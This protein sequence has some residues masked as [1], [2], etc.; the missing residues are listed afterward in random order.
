[1]LNIK[2]YYNFD[3]K[4]LKTLINMKARYTEVPINKIRTYIKLCLGVSRQMLTLWEAG[5]C[6]P[7]INN[8]IWFKKFF[9]V[10][11]IENFFEKEVIKN[12]K[13]N[14]VKGVRH[15]KNTRKKRKK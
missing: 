12:R 11:N 13:T 3:G 14:K 2:D 15:K 1:M 4:K 10:G 7:G 5:A 8:L 6:A 9:K